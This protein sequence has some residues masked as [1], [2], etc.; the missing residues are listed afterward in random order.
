MYS[1][2]P[3]LIQHVMPGDSTRKLGVMF[4][5]KFKFREY[6]SQVDYYTAVR[7]L[8]ILALRISRNYVFRIA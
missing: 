6:I 2:Y 8:I 7:I 3:Y 1:V 5:D 4:Y